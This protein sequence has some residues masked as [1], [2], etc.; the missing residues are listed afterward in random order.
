[1]KRPSFYSHFTVDSRK[2]F[3]L[4]LTLCLLLCSESLLKADSWPQILG[5][6]RNGISQ[7]KNLISSWPAAG[8]K[9]T[10]R[11]A[12]GVGMSGLVVDRGQVITMVESNQQQTVLALD[13][14]SGKVLWQTSV[15]P[16]YKNAMGAGSR[17][18]PTISG[19]QVFIFT[20]EGIL[21][22]LNFTTGKIEWTHNVVK[23]LKGKQAEYGMT[24]SPLVIG[25]QVI[26]TAGVSNAAVVSFDKATGKLNWQT[27]NETTGYSSAALLNVN[28]EQQ[29]VAF[30]G[31]A[32]L[33]IHPSGGQLLW[34]YPYVTDYNCNIVTPV[35]VDGDIF[36]SSGKLWV[37]TA[38]YSET[39]WQICRQ[40]KM[41]FA[42]I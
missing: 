26:V 21:A 1:M 11:V 5:P 23:E 40:R 34:R 32:L 30:T 3:L 24:S 42:Y 38:K 16:A 20:G 6:N 2:C 8:P 28:G 4:L 17:A 31:S 15:A 12:G 10:W 39:S 35:S 25:N 9:I 33:G 27:G 18:T 41:D 13:T 29:L 36:I 19:D 14:D 22:A 7:E 37:R